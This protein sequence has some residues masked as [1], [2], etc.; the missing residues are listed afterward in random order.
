MLEENDSIHEIVKAKATWIEDAKDFHSLSEEGTSHWP[1]LD[2]ASNH[3][4]KEIEA[5]GEKIDENG[6]RDSIIDVSQD[7]S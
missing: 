2:T 7:G 5:S 3:P 4:S 1:M 6:I